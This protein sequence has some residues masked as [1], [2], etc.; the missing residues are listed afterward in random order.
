M[1]GEPNC[2]IADLERQI[3]E[4]HAR[5]AYLEGFPQ[6]H[7]S[8][9]VFSCPIDQNAPAIAR[10]R[11]VSGHG[12]H[13]VSGLGI[14]ARPLDMTRAYSQ[15]SSIPTTSQ[16]I[17][18]NVYVLPMTGAPM[19]RPS[20]SMDDQTMSSPSGTS[21]Q[22]LPSVHEHGSLD[23]VGMDPGDYISNTPDEG[24]YLASTRMRLLP[25]EIYQHR[26]PACPSMYSGSSAQ[27]T[28][29]MTRQNSSFDNINGSVPT[30]NPMVNSL[31]SRSMFT[32]QP[33]WPDSQ[34][35]MFPGMGPTVEKHP[36]TDQDLLGFGTTF[37]SQEHLGFDSSMLF[38]P[39]ESTQM[40]RSISSTSTSSA[41]STG[42]NLARR[43]RERSEQVLRNSQAAIK[44]K[45]LEPSPGSIP[46][47][48][49]KPKPAAN[50]SSATRRKHPKV[51][52]KLCTD[53]PEFR[54]EHELQRHVNAKHSS[55]VT[56]YICRDPASRGLQSDLRPQVPLKGCKACDNGKL[57]GAYYNA[58]AHLRRWHFRP[59]PRGKGGRRSTDE[60]RGGSAGGHWPPMDVLKMWFEEKVVRSD[61]RHTPA[62][63]DNLD[64]DT[65]DAV[66]DVSDEIPIDTGMNLANADFDDVNMYS[67][68]DL[69]ASPDAHGFI[70][71]P[72]ADQ[73]SPLWGSASSNAFT[74]PTGDFCEP[75]F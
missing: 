13:N 41:R 18:S 17:R 36:D 47:S 53:R 11:S 5:N 46:A 2:T 50:K 69:F 44:P 20:S 40:E 54:G 31:S 67:Y 38:P 33:F 70:A 73:S 8:A 3:Q 7:P 63:S 75:S 55:S 16:P 64:E 15:H 9:P 32:E 45:M 57:Y 51:Q 28:S 72:F 10:S 4:V 29:P 12:F 1:S 19:N 48:A 37:P 52:C 62:E 56:K 23:G 58:A 26:P 27:E 6:S 34:P 65:E 59:R 43:V 39:T 49:Q 14:E 22:R 24:S 71:Q 61:E 25:T 66:M 21:P 35:S 30:S 74:P 42:S 60:R 68:E